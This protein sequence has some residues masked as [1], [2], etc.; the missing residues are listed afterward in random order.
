MSAVDGVYS[1]TGILEAS[2]HSTKTEEEQE[3]EWK[4]NFAD[5]YSAL[6]I[7][8]SAQSW[9]TLQKGIQYSIQ[10]QQAIVRQTS[11]LFENKS[12]VQTGFS[13]YLFIFYLLV[14]KFIFIFLSYDHPILNIFDQIIILL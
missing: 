1:I 7:P 2:F 10:L 13:F 4:D 8:P 3:D 6:S 11:S 14:V 12:L 9:A 5:A